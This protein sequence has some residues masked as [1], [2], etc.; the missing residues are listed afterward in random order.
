MRWD[1]LIVH[2]NFFVACPS[3]LKLFNEHFCRDVPRSLGPRCTSV[4]WKSTSGLQPVKGHVAK[5]APD[6]NR[7]LRY[8]SHELRRWRPHEFG[9]LRISSNHPRCYEI[10]DRPSENGTKWCTMSGPS[11]HNAGGCFYRVLLVCILLSFA[12]GHDM[13]W[14]HSFLIPS[15]ALHFWGHYCAGHSASALAANVPELAR[16]RRDGRGPVCNAPGAHQPPKP[17]PAAGRLGALSVYQPTC[18][19]ITLSDRSI[20][21]VWLSPPNCCWTSP[22]HPQC[23]GGAGEVCR[24]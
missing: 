7:F 5:P 18:T 10:W 22:G 11:M 4:C 2:R 19:R 24:K 20:L 8:N 16:A 23:K 3:N 13:T 12:C 6:P 17:L 15:K 9:F 21:Q 14:W 1:V